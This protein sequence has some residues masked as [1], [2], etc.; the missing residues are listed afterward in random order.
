MRIKDYEDNSISRFR[1]NLLNFGYPAS[2][3][4]EKV[5][6]GLE[7]KGQDKKNGAISCM[8]GKMQGKHARACIT[9]CK[10]NMQEHA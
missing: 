9:R 10:G 4:R 7:Q 6:D 5:S 8:H 2:I 3:G 1:R